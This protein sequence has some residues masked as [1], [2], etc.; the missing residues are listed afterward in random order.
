MNIDELLVGVQK[1]AR[2]IGGE[3]NSVKKEWS[4]DRVKV[5]L[6]FPDLYEVGMSYLGLKILYG[7]LNGR[8]DVLCERVF[9]PWPDFEEILSKTKTSLF[10]LESRRPIRD[11]DIIGI[12]LAYELTYTNV[13]NILDLGG[14]PKT[15]A[16]R[17]DGDPLIIAG[18]PTVY[19]PEP[20]ADFID[21]FVIGDGEEIVVEII[22]AYKS[23]RVSGGIRREK[24]LVNL[25]AIEGVYVPSLYRVEYKSDK[26]IKAIAPV[27]K[28]TPPKIIKR[29]VKDLDKSFYPTK[30][31]VPYLKI[32]HDRI[33]L[34]IMRGCKNACK[35][36][37]AAATYRPSRER[38]KDEIVKIAKAS[39]DATGYDEVS[40]LSLSSGDHPQIKEIISALNDT[41]KGKAVSISMPSLRVEDT[42]VGLPSMISQVKKSGLTFAPEAGSGRLRKV[43]NKNSDM[44]KLFKTLKDAF[45]AG[46]KR[47]KLYFM[48]GLPTETDSDIEGI[49]GLVNE[50]SESKRAIDGR[51]A[52][53]SVSVNA[54]V[55]KPHTLYE[56]EA[57]ASREELLR[58]RE[59]LRRGIRSRAIELDINPFDKSYLEAVFS[60][61]DRKLAEAI[62]AA[63][64]SGARF[65]GWQDF[66]NM[67]RW[68]TAF[69]DCGID[70]DFY[71]TRQRPPDELLPWSIIEI[72]PR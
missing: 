13:L 6:A 51:R 1:P 66:F 14:I 58:R 52:N 53:V 33:V 39:Y 60:R 71:A 47:I 3:W 20:M 50:V 11:F 72:K 27:S 57:M 54:F 8:D 68:Q 5:L 16:G 18:G 41:F 34:E 38:S 35:F 69:K 63:W 65:D 55:P 62:H 46:W 59:I 2:Y 70:P 9:S 37:Q 21:A 40:L 32:V 17:R 49:A 22:E 56:R 44:D 48:I 42:L 28:D 29:T 4:E 23:C 31:I 19:N 64:S 43:I 61:G 24:L 10:S 25:A 30:Q 15:S 7:I 36:C 67:D 45:K 26:T 12:S